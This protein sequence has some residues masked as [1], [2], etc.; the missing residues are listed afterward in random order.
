VE[1]DTG[2][3]IKV[4]AK[5]A[6]AVRLREFGPGENRDKPTRKKRA[7]GRPKKS[8]T[9]VRRT[10]SPEREITSAPEREIRR[11]D[12]HTV[13]RAVDR[14]IDRENSENSRVPP[15]TSKNKETLESTS[16]YH[17]ESAPDVTR[18]VPLE[19]VSEA[20]PLSAPDT[21]IVQPQPVA[22]QAAPAVVENI[23][24]P[25][26]RVDDHVPA[27]HAERLPWRRRG[28]GGTGGGDGPGFDAVDA[29]R[30]ATWAERLLILIAAG[31][32]ATA[33]YVSVTGMTVLFP[34]GAVVIVVL[35]SLIE[36]GK[37]VG[38][39][40]ISAGWRTYS[41]LSKWIVAGLL[42]T[43]ALINA[44]AVYGWLIS[45]HA[46]PAAARSATYT[47]RS[48][49][50]GAKQEVVQARLDDLNKRISIIDGAAEGAAKRGRSKSAI[51]AIESQKK[52]RAQLAAERDR[53]QQ[54]LAGLKAGRSGM[55]ARH[56]VDEA[57]AVPVRY[58]A[59]LFEDMGLIKPGTDPEKLIRWL[60][61]MILLCG[62]P[63]ALAVMVMVN[64]RARRQGGAR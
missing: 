60:S 64:S 40:V 44:A 53:V 12:E 48:A 15:T 36:A 19:D 62:D 24:T 59:A 37:F 8:R 38:F 63:L 46:G 22:E 2:G 10:A 27:R 5:P 57:A 18:H 31:L 39:G 23:R 32:S 26:Q 1:K 9:R 29:F 6:D 16:G 25:P 34:A 41:F 14:E 33:A 3:G 49:G 52:A 35:G 28:G 43:A 45:N 50:D 51:N 21:S 58:A 13:S 7:P 47:E 4:R 42:I 55:T 11:E 30:R 56:E 20:P 17:P 54:E 61:F